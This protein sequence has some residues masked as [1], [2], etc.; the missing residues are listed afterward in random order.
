MNMYSKFKRDV[1]AILL[2]ILS[3]PSASCA[4][5]M[6]TLTLISMLDLLFS[7]LVDGE[8]FASQ[9]V[10]GR[11]LISGPN[12]TSTRITKQIFDLSTFTH[13]DFVF[14]L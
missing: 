10:D 3:M 6:R 8:T 4:F 12:K 7:T 9:K 13:I 5:D 2:P 14:L 1:G 11:L